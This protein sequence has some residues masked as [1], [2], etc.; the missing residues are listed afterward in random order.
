MV[1]GILDELDTGARKLFRKKDSP[2]V[3]AIQNG[4]LGSLCDAGRSIKNGKKRIST[5]K[6]TTLPEIVGFNETHF[7]FTDGNGGD[8]EWVL[9]RQHGRLLRD[10]TP[11]CITR[12]KFNNW[13]FDLILDIHEDKVTEDTIRQLFVVAGRGI[14][15]GAFRPIRNGRFGCFEIVGWEVIGGNG[16]KVRKTSAI[17]KSTAAAAAGILLVCC[18]FL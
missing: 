12:P 2:E 15:I 10:N 1:V 13:G 17:K 4:V 3:N 9:D 18:L 11:V 5:A 8:P 7:N 14:G 6:T 16:G